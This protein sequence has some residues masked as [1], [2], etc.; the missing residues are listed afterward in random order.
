VKQRDQRRNG[1][2]LRIS[3]STRIPIK[4]DRATIYGS[5]HTG[6]S[7][8]EEKSPEK[9]EDIIQNHVSLFLFQKTKCIM[10]KESEQK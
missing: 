5:F 3:S 2:L 1:A 8:R 9:D 6:D 4:P 10:E 7:I